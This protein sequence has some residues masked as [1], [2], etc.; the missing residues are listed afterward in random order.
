MPMEGTRLDESRV[1]LD[2]VAE[3]KERYQY[4]FHMFLSTLNAFGSATSVEGSNS[5]PVISGHPLTRK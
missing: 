5:L 2:P 3:G 1:S 4:N